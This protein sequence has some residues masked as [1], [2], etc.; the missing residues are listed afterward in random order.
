MACPAGQYFCHDRGKC[1]PIPKGQKVR[2]DGE[3]VKEV[4]PP[5]WGHTKAEKE[6]TD[7]SKPKS[8][9]GGTAAAFKR[10]LDRGDFKGLPGDKTKKEKTASMF[11]LMWSMKKKGDKPH[12]KPGTDKKYKKYQEEQVLHE[13]MSGKDAKKLEKA[14]VLSYSDNPK[15]QDRAR[16]RQVDVDYKDLLRQLKAKKKNKYNES[17]EIDPS[18]HKKVQKKAKIRNLARDNKNP[19]EKAAAERKLG[20]KLF[21]EGRTFKD[22]RKAASSAFKKKVKKHEYP[23]GASGGDAGKKAKERLDQR[24]RETYV[25][26]FK[27][28]EYD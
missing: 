6:K 9:I 16:A 18:G 25:S 1:M 10:A 3:L 11:K 12:Y 4:A 20:P 15:D 22:W 8:K 13:T 7:P 19:N 17:F 26:P 24:E 28:V 23:A 2:K 27:P 14:S 21:G 5:G